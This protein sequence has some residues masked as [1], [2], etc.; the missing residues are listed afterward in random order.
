MM[1][2]SVSAFCTWHTLRSGRIWNHLPPFALHVAFPHSLA[3]RHAGDYYGGSV[4]LALAS[5]RRSRGTSSSHVRGRCR[6]PYSSPYLT[7]LANVHPCEGVSAPGSCRCT[8]RRSSNHKRGVPVSV[9]CGC[10]TTHIMG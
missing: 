3:G 10:S 2:R 4:A 8:A 1:L 9:R 5:C 6:C 7:S